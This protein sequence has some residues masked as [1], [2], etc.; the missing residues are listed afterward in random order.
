MNSVGHQQVLPNIM[1]AMRETICQTTKESI[2]LQWNDRAPELERPNTALLGHEQVQVDRF[3]L[4]KD[5]ACTS[6]YV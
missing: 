1:R 5:P 6:F 3:R 4:F 2:P